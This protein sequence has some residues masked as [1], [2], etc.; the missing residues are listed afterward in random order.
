[1]AFAWAYAEETGFSYWWQSDGI[2]DYRQMEELNDLSGDLEL[3]CALAELYVGRE[4]A[5]EADCDFEQAVVLARPARQ[6]KS[7]KLWLGNQDDVVQNQDDVVRNQD[8][9]V[10]EPGRRG[11]RT[12]TTWFKTR[13]T[14][15]GTRTT[16]F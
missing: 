12:R 16:W 1:M 10:R 6:K 5:E 15:F 2:I 13:T 11:F 14:W 9:V 3:W 8:R 4:L 7:K